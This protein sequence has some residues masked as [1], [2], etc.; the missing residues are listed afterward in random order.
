MHET[1][2]E[3]I[4]LDDCDDETLSQVI[5]NPGAHHPKQVRY[6]TKQKLARKCRVEGRIIEAIALE[7]IMQLLWEKLPE[8]LQW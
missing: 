4:N 6:A 2:Y 7:N 3:C 5:D 1:I 8:E